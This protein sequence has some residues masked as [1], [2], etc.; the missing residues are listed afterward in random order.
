M[1]QGEPD[2]EEALM[3][4][5]ES[6][7]RLPASEEVLKPTARLHDSPSLMIRD[8]VS[9]MPSDTYAAHWIQM[10]GFDPKELR[11]LKNG[12]SVWHM[13]AVMGRIDILEWLVSEH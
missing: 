3:A 7:L 8:K 5:A 1:W 13:A 11:E 4:L 9:P 2:S 12:Q 6:S 10:K